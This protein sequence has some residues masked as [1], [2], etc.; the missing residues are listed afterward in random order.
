MLALIGSGEY[1]TAM[2]PVDR[3]LIN[4]LSQPVRVVCLSTAAGQ[5]SSE[6]IAYWSK[7]GILHFERLGVQV[8]ALPVIDQ[9]SANNPEYAAT[10]LKMNFIYLSGGNPYYLYQTLAG[11]L[12]WQAILSV[13]EK[14]GLLAGCSAGAMIMGEKIFGF[15]G[16]RPGFGFIPGITI[17]PHF[18]EIP[19]HIMKLVHLITGK[20]MTLVGIE[21]NTALVESDGRFEVLGSA[22]VTVWTRTGKTRY[23]C[24]LLPAGLLARV[25]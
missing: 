17:L 19:P 13:L 6:R 21:G 20:N 22:G 9:A 7:L 10:I 11:S 18:D 14:G 4:R 23:T 3:E 5:E 25:Q 12:A 16:W 24:G 8:E 15:P 2:D 1:L